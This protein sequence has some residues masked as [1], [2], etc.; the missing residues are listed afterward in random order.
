MIGRSGIWILHWKSEEYAVYDAAVRE[1]FSGDGVS[2]YVILDR[3]QPEGRFG[4]SEFHSEKLGLF[5]TTRASY[6]AKNA[7]RFHIAPRF[8]LPHPFRMVRE[9][10]LDKIYNSGQPDSANGAELKALL[11]ESWGVITLSRVGF[12]LGGKHAVVY[13]QL[14]YCGLCGGGTYLYLSRETGAWHIVGRAG[15]WIS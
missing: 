6:A 10:E 8:N 11:Q 13:A 12:D 4:I 3:T 15:T 2:Y 7:L 14:T 5:L 9:E 1:A